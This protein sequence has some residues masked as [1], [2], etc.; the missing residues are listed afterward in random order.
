MLTSKAAV[1]TQRGE[2]RGEAEKKIVALKKKKK[3][4]METLPVGEN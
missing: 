3:K 4:K 1:L 2:G